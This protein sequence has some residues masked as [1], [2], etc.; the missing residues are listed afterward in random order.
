MTPEQRSVLAHVVVDPEAWHAHAVATFGAERAAEMLAAKAARWRPEYEAARGAPGYK[1][2]AARDAA[3]A[4][5]R[6]RMGF[7]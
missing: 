2:R 1:P 7:V 5:S 4:A 3:D 6:K